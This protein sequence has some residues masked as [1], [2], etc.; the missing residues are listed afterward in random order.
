MCGSAG[1]ACWSIDPKGGMEFGR[2]QKLFTGFAHD[3]GEN[4]LGLLRA[5]TTVMQQRAQRLRGQTRLHTPTTAEP[6]IVLIV[7]EIASLTAYIGDRKIRA[8]V[9][10]LLGLLLSQGRAVGVSVIA[11]VQDP[12]KDV[13]PIR[14]LFSIRVGL[15]MTESTQTTMVLGAAGPGGG[16]GLR[17]HSHQ[18]PRCRL[19]VRGR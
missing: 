15:R 5:V 1:C 4:T 11:A 8:E 14:Q 7:D 16:R 19:R 17:P 10:Q 2:G 9:E 18:H 3:N 12:S 13:L 6:L